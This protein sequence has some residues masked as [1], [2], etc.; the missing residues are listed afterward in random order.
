MN[1]FIYLLWVG[2]ALFGNPFWRQRKVESQATKGQ[3]TK[4]STR[5]PIHIN[6]ALLEEVIWTSSKHELLRRS[7]LWYLAF[8][9]SY[10]CQEAP[11]ASLEGSQWRCEERH[12]SRHLVNAEDQ[13]AMQRTTNTGTNVYMRDQYGIVCKSR[14]EG[15][16]GGHP[17]EWPRFKN[18]LWIE[19]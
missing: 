18:F 2:G 13:Q 11:K 16:G 15:R 3:H 4:L 17:L 8:G 1:Y 6:C 10:V 12:R 14:T 5:H 9:A 19:C 7:T